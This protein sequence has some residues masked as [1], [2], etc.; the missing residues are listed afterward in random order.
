MSALD[1]AFDASRNHI[2]CDFSRRLSVKA[3]L[4]E[5]LKITSDLRRHVDCDPFGLVGVGLAGHRGFWL[6]VN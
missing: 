4:D 6:N 2:L 1:H 5:P 3:A